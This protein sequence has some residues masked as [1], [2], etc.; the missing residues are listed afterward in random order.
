MRN[1]ALLLLLGVNAEDASKKAVVEQANRLFGRDSNGMFKNQAKYLQEK[2][3]L[4][5]KESKNSQMFTQIEDK[6]NDKTFLETAVQNTASVM[7]GGDCDCINFADTPAN[8]GQN[9]NY[10]GKSTPWCYTSTKCK[11][12]DGISTIDDTTPWKRCESPS[13]TK[14]K[15][16]PKGCGC[17]DF[18]NTPANCGQSYNYKG[19]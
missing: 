19:K 2:N 13:D 11:G 4:N 8:C 12:A 14:A 1:L 3:E 17:I 15:E 10:K 9:Y 6:L 7:G 18:H 5:L 16:P